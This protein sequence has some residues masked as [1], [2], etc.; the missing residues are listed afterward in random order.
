MKTYECYTVFFFW[1]KPLPANHLCDFDKVTAFIIAR[2]EVPNLKNKSNVIYVVIS[3]PTVRYF[4]VNRTNLHTIGQK[5]GVANLD[6]NPL[7]L[8]LPRFRFVQ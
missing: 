5:L 1:L 3:D 8:R 4:L 2:R 7:P 6:S